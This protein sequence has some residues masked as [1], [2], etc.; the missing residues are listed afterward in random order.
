MRTDVCPCANF[1]EDLPCH[2]LARLQIRKNNFTQTPDFL[3]RLQ[4]L[5]FSSHGPNRRRKPPSKNL[6]SSSSS[7]MGGGLMI[8]SAI[9]KIRIVHFHLHSIDALNLTSMPSPRWIVTSSPTPAHL[10]S[11]LWRLELALVTLALASNVCCFLEDALRA[12]ALLVCSVAS[13]LISLFSNLGKTVC[14]FFF[15]E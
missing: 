15:N 3:G 9:V 2:H 8:R 10:P 12:R 7:E 13:S 5:T 4:T 1:E 6:A 14:D 11:S